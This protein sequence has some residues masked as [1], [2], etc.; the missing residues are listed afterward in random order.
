MITNVRLGG[1]WLL[2]T[3]GLAYFFPVT[4]EQKGFVT[5][6]WDPNNGRH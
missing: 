1:K 5:L 4:E 6:N 3:N 2:E